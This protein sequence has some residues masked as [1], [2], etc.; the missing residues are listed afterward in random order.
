MLYRLPSLALLTVLIAGNPTLA[1]AATEC[2]PVAIGGDGLPDNA[3][4]QFAIDTCGATGG[5][6]VIDQ[7]FDIGSRFDQ[8]IGN[9][10]RNMSLVVTGN[11]KALT[12][13][14]ENGGGFRAV[15]DWHAATGYLLAVYKNG[16]PVVLRDLY[17]DMSGRCEGNDEEV[18]DCL[19]EQQHALEVD[20]GGQRILVDHLTVYHP[21]LGPSA[22]GD[23]V[24][25]LG[26]YTSSGSELVRTITI[27]DFVALACDRSVFG[28]QRGVRD[29]LIDGFVSVG[30]KDNDADVEPTGTDPLDENTWT[31]DVTIRRAVISKAGGN[32][33]TIGRGIRMKVQDSTI[34]GGGIFSVSCRDCQLTGN[35]ILQAAGSGDAPIGAI[36][37]NERLKIIGNR[38]GRLAGSTST[39]ALLYVASNNDFYPQD[40]LIMGND[41]ATS[42]AAPAIRLENADAIVLGNTFRYTGSAPA[43]ANAIAVAVRSLA[44]TLQMAGAVISG[45]RFLGPWDIAVRLSGV[46][47]GLIGA[48]TVTGNVF[49]GPRAAL[50]CVNWALAYPIPPVRTGNWKGGSTIDDCPIAGA[51]Y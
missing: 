25:M 12:I 48:V 46:A 32:A 22:G 35:T 23:C 51:G 7:L 33:I 39:E 50:Q 47:T 28:F 49:D 9:P 29:A 20:Y 8:P 18:N 16:A 24:R 34:I 2:R 44:G 15:G 42:Y 41:F 45:N 10:W 31:Q 14:A 17:L 38:L 6:V 21:S 11:T 30:N 27:R 5:D 26:N 43:G 13:R 3:A 19:D 40:T 4:V 36:R 1:A 37:S